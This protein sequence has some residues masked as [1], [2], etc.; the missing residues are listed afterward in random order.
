MAIRIMKN[1]IP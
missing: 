1:S